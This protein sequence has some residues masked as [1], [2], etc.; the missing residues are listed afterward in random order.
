MYVCIFL[1]GNYYK[2]VIMLAIF[3]ADDCKRSRNQRLNV[4]SEARIHFRSF[5]Y[6]H[7]SRLSNTNVLVGEIY[8]NKYINVHKL[9]KILCFV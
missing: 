2:F 5:V 9:N 3:N 7:L 1:H 4:P 6:Y 8:A